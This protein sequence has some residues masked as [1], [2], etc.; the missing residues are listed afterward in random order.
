MLASVHL[1]DH[2]VIDRIDHVV[3]GFAADAGL[4]SL[5][6]EVHKVHHSE[7]NAV[8]VTEGICLVDCV[9]QK[10]QAVDVVGKAVDLGKQC[11]LGID[12]RADL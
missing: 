9:R 8:A 1:A 10:G 4:L 5:H 2:G 12:D 6:R 3:H 7:G 11:L